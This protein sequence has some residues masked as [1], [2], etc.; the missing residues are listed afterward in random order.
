MSFTSPFFYV[1]LAAVSGIFY[2]I[3]TR[4]RTLYLL[5]AS[6]VF[7]LTNNPWYLLLLIS[8]TVIAYGVAKAFTRPISESQ[9]TILLWVGIIPIVGMLVFFKYEGSFSGWLLPL[10]MSYYTFKL[11]SY[12]VEAYW[13]E[14]QVEHNFI[15]FALY[16]A[17]AP[18]I[19]S[20]PIQRSAPFF[21]QLIDLK[22][23]RVD[24]GRIEEGF[25]LILAGLMMKLLI[26]DKL[27]AFVAAVDGSIAEYERSVAVTT[28]VC[29]TLQLYAD[30]AGYTNI[31]IGI[32]KIFG[33]DAP[34]NFNAP[35]AAP[36]IQEMW[37]RWHMSLTSWVTDYLFTPLHMVLR[38]L[39]SWSM[40]IAITINMVVIG[41][42]H[43][44]T[45][46]FLIFGL[47]H[48][49]FVIITA[50]SRNLRNRLWGTRRWLTWMRT[51]IGI[52]L[53]FF[54]M[55]FTQI[56]W[57]APSFSEALLRFKLIFGV[58]PAGPSIWKDI[59]ME[60]ADP[61]IPCM[62]IAFYFGVGAPG[63]SWVRAKIN[64]IIPNWVR[65]GLAILLLSLLSTEAGVSFIYGRF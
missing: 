5:L 63:L 41:L 10:G 31:A 37:R 54:L 8:A 15:D 4:W 33:I 9:R 2:L 39:G 19:V 57:H 29:Y 40:I 65:Y 47:F 13:D 3:P 6:Y 60:V 23:G 22:S 44:L 53:T 21:K 42:W 18:Q 49:L 48:A 50:F 64:P 46:N 45:L 51:G 56:F 32:G 16:P 14:R 7:Y 58:I 30:F 36:N 62:I 28:I 35:F 59:Q 55:T 43:G 27:G 12:I 25:R 38:K 26:G 20:G 1:Y 34:P 61:L 52:I 24:Y 11:I 17:F